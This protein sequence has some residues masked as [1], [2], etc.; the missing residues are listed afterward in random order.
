MTKWPLLL[1]LI[2]IPVMASLVSLPQSAAQSAQM[3][4][5][6][7]QLALDLK[8]GMDRSTLTEDQKAQLRNQFRELR[9]AHQNH[10]PFAAMRAA[11]SIRTTLDSGAFKPEDRDRI[12]Q[13]MEAIRK[14][15]EG[16]GSGFGASRFHRFE[17]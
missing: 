6:V 7:E 3:K 17:Q 15:R 16:E 13:D 8:V 10:E 1:V 5:D 4:D 12:K 2:T 14:A 11:R 9:R